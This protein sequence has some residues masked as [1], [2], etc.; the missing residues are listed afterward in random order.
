MGSGGISGRSIRAH[1]LR[2]ARQEIAVFVIEDRPFVLSRSQII[3]RIGQ[4][5]YCL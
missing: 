1:L 2:E 3:E 4:R 5:I